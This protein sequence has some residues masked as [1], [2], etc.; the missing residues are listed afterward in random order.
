MLT[1][2]AALAFAREWID[3]WNSHDLDRILSHYTDDFE[4]T[5]PLIVEMAG[6]PSG[7][8]QGKAAVG[9]YWAHALTAHPGLRFEHLAT[10]AGMGSVA[11]QFRWEGGVATEV[12]FFTPERKVHR[13]FAHHAT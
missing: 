10:F 4:M 2:E 13:A 5:S 8:L 7:R 6:E 9:T 11:L 1:R 12:F 3:S